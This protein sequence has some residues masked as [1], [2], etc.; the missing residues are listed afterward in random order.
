[1][2]KVAFRA[3]PIFEAGKTSDALKLDLSI[4]VFL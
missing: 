3:L 4:Y 1:M 2:L